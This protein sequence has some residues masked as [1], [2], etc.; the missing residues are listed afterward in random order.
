M[1]TSYEHQY[2]Y[3]HIFIQVL[4]LLMG[5]IIQTS[6]HFGIKNGNHFKSLRK[7]KLSF[8]LISYLRFLVGI[9]LN[10]FPTTLSDLD[11]PCISRLLL[12]RSPRVWLGFAFAIIHHQG[13]EI[14]FID[15]KTTSTTTTTPMPTTKL[16]QLWTSHNRTFIPI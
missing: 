6:W 13:C 3:F 5:G 2:L 16:L 11:N 4:L 15:A 9:T 1:F 10:F 8:A 14:L 7:L 12:S